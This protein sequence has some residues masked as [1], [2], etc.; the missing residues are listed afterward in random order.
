MLTV[1]HGDIFN[2]PVDAIVNPAYTSLLTGSGL[3]GEIHK[4]EGL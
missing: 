1:T 2:E 3:C 4:R